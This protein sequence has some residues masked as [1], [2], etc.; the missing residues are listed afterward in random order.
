PQVQGTGNEKTY[1]A[2]WSVQRKGTLITQKLVSSTQTASMRIWFS[3]DL[4]TQE[5]GGWIF[6]RTSNSNA[7]AAV[8]VVQ[9]SYSWVNDADYPGKWAVCSQ[10]Y[11]PVIIE[12]ARNADYLDFEDFKDTV[13]F[14]NPSING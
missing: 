8:K 7:F 12:A 1:N 3:S 13:L 14:N 9:G 2:H 11:S 4:V 5:V 6:A 10:Q